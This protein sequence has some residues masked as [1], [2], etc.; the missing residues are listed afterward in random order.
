MKKI[1]AIKR[2]LILCSK[3]LKFAT[4]SLLVSN[5]NG[6]IWKVIMG[7]GGQYFGVPMKSEDT[8]SCTRDDGRNLVEEWQAAHPEG[9]FVNNTQDLMSVDISKASHVLGIFSGSHMPYH[10]VK[11]SE[12]PS[13]SNMTLQA[14]RMLKKN[15]NGFLLMVSSRQYR[16]WTFM[17]KHGSGYTVKRA[18]RAKL[19]Y[20]PWILKWH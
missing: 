2:V 15:K 13:L 10:A 1:S 14:I 12:T 9:K 5:I 11:S 3:Y 18:L 6:I 20:A 7:G 4:M 16:R 8:D 19:A 17:P